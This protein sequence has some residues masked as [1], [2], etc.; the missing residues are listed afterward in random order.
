MKVSRVQTLILSLIS[1]ALSACDM[2]KAKPVDEIPKITVAT[3]QTK[4][5]T[6]TQEYVCQLHSRHH[7][8]VRAPVEGYL[9]AI[10]AREGHAVKL[11]DLLFQVKPHREKEKQEPTD[12]KVISI[13]A[14]FDGVLGRLASQQ[15][16]FVQKGEAL[17]TLSDHN[18]MRADFSVPEVRYLE[19]RAAN[20]NNN[21]L[22]IDLLLANGNKYAQPGKIGV[23]GT[24]F[25]GGSVAFHADF[26]NPEH[27]LRPGQT[28]T[29][30]ISHVQNDAVVVPQ[31]AT[32]EILDRKFVYVVDKNDVVH[33][34]EIVVQTE[35]D[36][37]FVVKKG[38]RVGDKI[39]LE[40]ARFVRDGSKVKYEDHSPKKVVANL[41]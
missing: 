22:Q 8:E 34:R 13:K 9:T 21:D 31:R 35:S 16:S 15:G 32:L 33:Q 40:G 17:T 27:L 18:L 11:G 28:G 36:D 38:V 10:P 25:K 6:L 39:V 30:V 24:E 23:I 2:D 3:V 37:L 26:P 12:D 14:P 5:V 20:P 1:L 19:D 7:I 41:K 4:A 29:V